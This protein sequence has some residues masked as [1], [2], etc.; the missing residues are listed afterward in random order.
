MIEKMKS[1]INETIYLVGEEDFEKTMSRLLLVSSLL[2]KVDDVVL[3][4]D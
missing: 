1:L 4:E 3:K 2:E